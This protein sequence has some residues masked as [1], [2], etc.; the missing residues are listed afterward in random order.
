MLTSRVLFLKNFRSH[1]YLSVLFLKTSIVATHIYF[2]QFISLRSFPPKR[3]VCISL[4]DLTSWYLLHSDPHRS[5]V[6]ILILYRRVPHRNVTRNWTNI[7]RNIASDSLRGYLRQD[8]DI[9]ALEQSIDFAP[10][11]TESW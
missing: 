3:T 4:L 8:Q 1:T 5:R 2:P 7:E 6:R 10:G 9:V 11:G